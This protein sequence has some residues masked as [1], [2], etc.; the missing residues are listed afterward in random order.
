[1]TFYFEILCG[2]AALFL[3]VYYYLTST[4]DFW[5]NCGVPGPKPV[6]IFGTARDLMI[7][8]TPLTEY[9]KSIYE[10]YRNEPMVGTF[11]GRTPCVILHD[12]ELIKDVLIKDFSTFADRGF[13]EVFDKTEPLSC[14]IFNLESTRWRPLRAKLSPVFTS[15]KLRDMFHLIVECSRN[16]ETYL[17]KE[18]AKGEPIECRELTAKFTTDVIGSCAFGIDM[19]SMSD[20]EGEFRR[21]G[22]QVFAT[23]LENAI[24]F[25][26][27]QFC[28][29]FYA[30][31]GYVIPD[32]KYTPFFTKVVA[33]TIKY[34]KEHNVIRPDFIH[35][36]MQLQEHPDK[37]DNVEFTNLLLTAQA[38]VFFI[39]GFETSS[40]TMSNALYELAKNQDIQDKLREEIRV[41]WANTKGD[42]KYEDVKGMKYLDKVFKETLRK[43]PPGVVLI[44]KAISDYTFSGTKVTIQKGNQVW[45]PVHALHTDPNFYPNP[46]K[47]DPERFNEDAVAARHPMTYLPFGDGPRNCIGARFAS[48][49]SK[50]GL[51]AILKNHRVDVCE[52]TITTYDVDPRA[53]I[54]TPIGGIYLKIT[55][56]ES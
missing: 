25:K 49:Q 35:L 44:R 9:T 53:F 51:I 18:I 7:A 24:R 19:N 17:D 12:L 15:G 14:H 52:K 43:Y 5:K 56:I 38:F 41:T 50:V 28:P 34:R 2:I 30:L 13:T 6:P 37:L 54:P 8:K 1:M 23:N 16:F 21:L 11:L 36:L 48:N 55:K 47:F 22:R 31:L 27:K 29:K 32:N 3:V 26:L 45:T 40:T 42:I 10:Q 39:A 46:E 4:F 33:D 20:E